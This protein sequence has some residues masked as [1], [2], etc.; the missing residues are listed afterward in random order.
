MFSESCRGQDLAQSLIVDETFGKIIITRSNGANALDEFVN[1]FFKY[2]AHRA[3][4]E[5]ASHISFVC[6]AG[7]YNAS[8]LRPFFADLSNHGEAV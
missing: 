4:L 2:V 6:V 8:H 1:I 7:E 5:G 3:D